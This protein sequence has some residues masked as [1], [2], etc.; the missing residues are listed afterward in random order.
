MELPQGILKIG[1]S[2]S[3]CNWILFALLMTYD[4]IYAVIQDKILTKIN[5]LVIYNLHWALHLNVTPKG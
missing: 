2:E 1:L 3:S 5:H 4:L